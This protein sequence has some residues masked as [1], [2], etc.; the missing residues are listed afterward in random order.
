M[1]M[2]KKLEEKKA[3]L[4]AKKFYGKYLRRAW[5]LCIWKLIQEAFMIPGTIIPMAKFAPLAFGN[6]LLT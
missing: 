5:K 1:E 4:P 3:I 2:R 6:G